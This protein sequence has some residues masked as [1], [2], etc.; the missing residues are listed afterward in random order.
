MSE[1]IAEMESEERRVKEFL[2][3]YLMDRYPSIYY[4]LCDMIEQYLLDTFKIHPDWI[5]LK[6]VERVVVRLKEVI[7]RVIIEGKGDYL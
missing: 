2:L 5:G 6:Q 4:D 1:N 3:E 7:G